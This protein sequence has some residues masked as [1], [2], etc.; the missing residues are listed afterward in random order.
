MKIIKKES[1]EEGYLSSLMNEINILRSLDH[2]HI[3]KLYDIYQDA[4]SIYM[5]T[6]YMGG[7]G[8]N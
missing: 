1:C 8:V 2:P 5:I 3:I 6:E 4:I 7:G